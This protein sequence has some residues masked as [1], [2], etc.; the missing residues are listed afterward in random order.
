MKFGG[1][2]VGSPEAMV[3]DGLSMGD[4]VRRVGQVVLSQTGLENPTRG[5]ISRA[6]LRAIGLRGPPRR[7]GH[8]S[9]VGRAGG[10][11]SRWGNRV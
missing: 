6:S 5:E 4:G 9:P 11:D 1:T 7:C 2:S 8:C 3:P 10:A